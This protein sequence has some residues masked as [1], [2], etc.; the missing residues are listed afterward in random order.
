MTTGGPLKSDRLTFL[1]PRAHEVNAGA[2]PPTLA[3]APDTETV[4][5]EPATVII[6]IAVAVAATTTSKGRARPHFGTGRDPEAAER[7]APDSITRSESHHSRERGRDEQQ[8]QVSQRVVEK[9]HC[10][11]AGVV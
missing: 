9:R 3:C 5:G 2:V 6:A 11:M 7:L 1:P 8:G 10:G 4:F